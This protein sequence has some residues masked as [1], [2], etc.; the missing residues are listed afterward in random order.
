MFFKLFVLAALVAVA[1]SFSSAACSEEG[2]CLEGDYCDAA[3]N[4][5]IECK[6]TSATCVPNRINCNK[7]GFEYLKTIC[8]LTCGVCAKTGTPQCGDNFTG[9]GNCEQFKKM[10]FCNNSFYKISYRMKMCGITCGL[11]P[12]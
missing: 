7:P 5:C 6:D 4:T 8:P 3:T 9:I 10:G 2:L 1:T 12:L 11:C